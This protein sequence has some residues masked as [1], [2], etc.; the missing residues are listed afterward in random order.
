MGEK[1]TEARLYAVK[2]YIEMHY[3]APS[4]T[5]EK[6]SL[7]IASD[8]LQPPKKKATKT[9]QPEIKMDY[10]MSRSRNLRDVVSEVEES[11]SQHLMRYI[12]E[13]GLRDA[14]VYKKANIDRKLFSKIKNEVEYKPSKVTALVLAL[15]LEMNLDETKDLIGRAGYALSHSDKRDLIIEYYIKLGDYDL[16]EINEALLHFNQQMLWN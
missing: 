15:A 4:D 6:F 14:D 1:I 16:Y 3:D 11:F 9:K 13:H 12:R 7:Q 8:S 10:C 2:K 5:C